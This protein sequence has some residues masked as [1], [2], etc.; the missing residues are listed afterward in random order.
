MLLRLVSFTG[1]ALLFGLVGTV[2]QAVL[3]LRA[4]S[5]QGASF[6]SALAVYDLKREVHWWRPIRFV[7]H[8][9]EVR[10]ALRD[11]P[12]E[13]AAYRRLHAALLSWSLLAT[14]A[15]WALIGLATG[16]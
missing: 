8:Q 7:G 6:A 4:L 15:L 1:I 13:A 11:S 9:R 12:K 2:I 10:R 14:G 16:R 3:S 5:E